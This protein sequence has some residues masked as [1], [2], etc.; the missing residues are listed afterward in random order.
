MFRDWEPELSFYM[1]LVGSHR[2]RG[3]RFGFLS[4][5][6]HVLKGHMLIL[7]LHRPQPVKWRY[8]LL[9]RLYQYIVKYPVMW[10]MS[11]KKYTNLCQIAFSKD[12][13]VASPIPCDLA[14]LPPRSP[15][16]WTWVGCVYFSQYSIWQMWCY[17]SSLGHER[18]YRFSLVFWN[19]LLRSLSY[20]VGSPPTL[21]LLCFDDVLIPSRGQV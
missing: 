13:C 2:Y 8:Y 5:L 3:A 19:T 20:H 14:T 16:P 7:Y 17:D 11:F 10:Q 4:H 12:G 18:Q 6:G 9:S 15:C 1:T 21:R